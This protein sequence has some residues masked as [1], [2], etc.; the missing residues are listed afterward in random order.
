MDRGG[1]FHGG[2]GESY[3]PHDDVGGS[4]EGDRVGGRVEPLVGSGEV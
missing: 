1:S 2:E 3:L 4:S